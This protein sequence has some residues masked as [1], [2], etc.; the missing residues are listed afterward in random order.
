[1]R[2]IWKPVPGYS[3]M[4]WVSNTG[5]LKSY[6]WWK[7]RGVESRGK[8]FLIKP[9]KMRDGHLLAR[10]WMDGSTKTVSMAKLILTVFTG[11]PTKDKRWACH[12]DGNP[13][14]N[15]I[16]NLRWGTNS[17]NQMDRVRHG[18]SN[19]GSANGRSKLSEKDVLA[20]H[21]RLANGDSQRAIATDFKVDQSAISN[22]ARGRNW[23]QLHP[24]NRHLDPTS[25]VE[26]LRGGR[27]KNQGRVA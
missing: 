25:L 5:R 21:T 1:M 11:P 18:T 26:P 9:M 23:P 4:Y 13:S 16:S 7:Q 15:L 2:V 12:N 3:G 8:A 20:I 19:R 10:L 22:I 6:R 14:N 24:S 17:E 27:R